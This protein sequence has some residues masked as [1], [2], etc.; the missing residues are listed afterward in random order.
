M[1]LMKIIAVIFIALLR[2]I[3]H[4][5]Y[6]CG[7]WYILVLSVKNFIK[8]LL[9]FQYKTSSNYSVWILSAPLCAM[10]FDQRY[11]IYWKRGGWPSC[12]GTS[13]PEIYWQ[14]NIEYM[15]TCICQI[16]RYIR[17]YTVVEVRALC[18]IPA[19]DELS[20][21]Y[22]KDY[23]YLDNKIFTLLHFRSLSQP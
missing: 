2:V 22:G 16:M 1:R 6:F 11:T 14:N 20:V 21:N 4:C 17:R 9:Q 12:R 7:K 8:R 18:N 10:W 5:S 13:N 23:N 15:D 3:H 19:G